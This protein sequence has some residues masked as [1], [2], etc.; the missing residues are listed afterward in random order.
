MNKN[1]LKKICDK[2]GKINTWA[3]LK[4]KTIK[5]I[6]P[7]KEKKHDVKNKFKREFLEANAKEASGWNHDTTSAK[8]LEVTKL[9]KEIDN[10]IL[11]DDVRHKF[12]EK[13][14][15]RQHEYKLWK[16]F[17]KFLDCWSVAKISKISN[18]SKQNL[19]KIFMLRIRN[20]ITE[21]YNKEKEEK[22]NIKVTPDRFKR[23]L[24]LG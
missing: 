18:Y 5:N 9:A 22:K 3:C 1:Q 14:I 4:C 16:L 11:A 8:D 2:C 20:F 10:S 13:H 19:Q 12:E 17:N 6:F 7:F 23:T 15:F 24:R 21:I